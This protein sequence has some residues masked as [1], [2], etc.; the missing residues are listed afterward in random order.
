MIKEKI[1]ESSVPLYEI[2]AD[3]LVLSWKPFEVEK[4]DNY[5]DISYYQEK[6]KYLMTSEEPEEDYINCKVSNLPE[7]ATVGYDLKEIDESLVFI[8][9]QRGE[10]R[11]P[12]SLD[13][14]SLSLLLEKECFLISPEE[15]SSRYE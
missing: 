9:N 12:R 15:F 7:W 3:N 13:E 5:Y 1:M 6:K 11:V 14:A 2:M 4:K 10:Y 8:K